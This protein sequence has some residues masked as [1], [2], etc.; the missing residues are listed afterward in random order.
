MSNLKKMYVQ[1][2]KI[3]MEDLKEDINTLTRECRERKERD[4]ISSYVYMEN[5]AVLNHEILDIESIS[6]ELDK[7][8]LG[9]FADLDA[10]IHHLVTKIEQELAEHNVMEAVCDLVK[11]KMRKVGEY[12]RSVAD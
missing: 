4:E 7:L 11:R 12:V 5:L 2:L 3:E 6:E 9:Q 10:L 1:I 8:D